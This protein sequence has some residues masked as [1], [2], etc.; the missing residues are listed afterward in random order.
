LRIQPK[1]ALRPSKQTVHFVTQPGFQLQHDWGGIVTVIASQRCKVNFTVNT[2]GYS[3][4]FHAWV[5][6]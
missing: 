4:R 2:L 6:S 3:R 1:R 5:A